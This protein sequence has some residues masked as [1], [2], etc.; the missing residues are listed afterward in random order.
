VRG[1]SQGG[2]KNE[3][4]HWSRSGTLAL[5]NGIRINYERESSSL[6]ELNIDGQVWDLRKGAV[7]QINAEG[8]VVQR[9]IYPPLIREENVAE[10]L[11]E[12]LPNS[13]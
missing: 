3:P 8:S 4:Q 13:E 2:G 10:W 12:T 6:P 11:K 9:P 5:P 7:F 1:M